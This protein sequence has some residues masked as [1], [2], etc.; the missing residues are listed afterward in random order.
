MSN[1]GLFN[2]TSQQQQQRQ[3]GNPPTTSRYTGPFSMPNPRAERTSSV[4]LFSSLQAPRVAA[5]P[6]APMRPILQM[7]PTSV[8]FRS[9]TGMKAVQLNAT[10]NDPVGL[11][12]QYAHYVS[13]PPPDFQVLS[14]VGP[15]HKPLFDMQ[16]SSSELL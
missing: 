7:G 3:Y 5:A 6:Q 15:S 11:L 16:V 9:F 2:V 13:L 10:N 8:P 14:S 1:I 4:E 12:I